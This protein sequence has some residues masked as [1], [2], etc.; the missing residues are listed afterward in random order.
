MVKGLNWKRLGLLL[1]WLMLSAFVV[2]AVVQSHYMVRNH[3]K[4]HVIGLEVY[5]DQE[6]SQPCT[7]IDWG[8]LYP[9]ESAT[10]TVYIKL[11]GNTPATLSFSVGDWCPPEA[12]TY[13]TVSWNYGGQIVN[14]NSVLPVEFTLSVSPDI[15]AIETFEFTITITATG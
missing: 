4:V 1:P 15:T 5:W 13:I 7:L 14:P 10:K 6:C 9:G 11:G 8:K 2:Y 12:A 3:G